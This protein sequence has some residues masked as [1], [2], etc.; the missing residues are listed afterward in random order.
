[1]THSETMKLAVKRAAQGTPKDALTILEEGIREAQEEGDARWTSM[2]A[3]SAAI[4][5]EQIGETQLAI[6][7]T[8]TAAEHSPAD[9]SFLLNL[10]RLYEGTG[11]REQCRTVLGLC[12]ELC[13]RNK[14]GWILEEVGRMLT[15]LSADG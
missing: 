6:R 5:S 11:D 7:Y 9:P 10:A 8:R 15:R 13:A 3:A 4:M 1:M 14:D 2:F 12:R